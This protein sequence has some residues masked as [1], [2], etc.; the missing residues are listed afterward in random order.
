M[1]ISFHSSWVIEILSNIKLSKSHFL[2]YYHHQYM[3]VLVD[4]YPSPNLELSVSLTQAILVCEFI[5]HA[6]I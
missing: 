3:K 2:I 6:L 1:D 5:S 4:Q